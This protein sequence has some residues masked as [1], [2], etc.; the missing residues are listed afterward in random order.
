LQPEVLSGSYT[1]FARFDRRGDR[2][3]LQL[4]LQLTC[5]SGFRPVSQELN[6][7]I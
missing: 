4:W 2:P 7:F 6:M 1:M 3:Q 5:S